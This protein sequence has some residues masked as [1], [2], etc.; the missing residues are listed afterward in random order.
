MTLVKSNYRNLNN[1]FDEF[2]NSLPSTLSRNSNLPPVNIFE[3][4]DTYSL[5]LVAPGL[6]KEDFK[7][8]IENGFITI[9]YEKKTEKETKDEKTISREF[10]LS[11]FKR[12]FMVD[13]TIDAEGIEAKYENGVLKLTLPKKEEVKVLP[14]EIAIQ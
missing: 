5:E 7:V 6:S 10:W 14:K 12:T 4:K 3:N 13:E 1:L 2:F 9:S 11:S 8:N